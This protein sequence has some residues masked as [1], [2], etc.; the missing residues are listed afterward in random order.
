MHLIKPK[1]RKSFST[2]KRP[3][4]SNGINSLTEINYKKLR[5]PNIENVI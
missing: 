3:N 1:K 4:T 5:L 2:G